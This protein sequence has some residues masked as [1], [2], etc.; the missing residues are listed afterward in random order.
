MLFELKALLFPPSAKP[1]WFKKLL[2]PY[3]YIVAY[4]FLCYS[5][6]F[7]SA[8]RSLFLTSF[9]APSY[10]KIECPKLFKDSSLF[11]GS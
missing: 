8:F 5:Y 10:V 11:I 3:G 9:E 1:I 6:A 7:S 2:F 4:C